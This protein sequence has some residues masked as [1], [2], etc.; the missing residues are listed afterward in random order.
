M[1]NLTPGVLLALLGLVIYSELVYRK[2]FKASGG[3][4]LSPVLLKALAERGRIT[5]PDHLKKAGVVGAGMIVL[6]VTGEHIHLLPAVTAL[7]GTTAL[8]VWIRPDIEGR[9]RPQAAP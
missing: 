3:H 2:E 4:G 5:E 7:L 1:V 8:L 9:E 6:F